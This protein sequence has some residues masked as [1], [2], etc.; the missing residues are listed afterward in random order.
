MENKNMK[1]NINCYLEL[2]STE[3]HNLIEESTFLYDKINSKPISY[4]E[5]NKSEYSNI[6]SQINEIKTSE[7]ALLDCKNDCITD[8]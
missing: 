3:I 2:Y 1:E 6:L 4:W 8:L 7:K 5:L